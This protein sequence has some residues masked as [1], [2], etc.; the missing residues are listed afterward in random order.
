MEYDD[1]NQ[2]WPMS[3]DEFNKIGD[4]LAND[5]RDGRPLR[6]TIITKD[7]KK[8]T[9]RENGAPS[10]HELGRVAHAHLSGTQ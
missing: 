5:V 7:G 9:I 10:R 4:N 2:K 1:I 3:D 6:V 8:I